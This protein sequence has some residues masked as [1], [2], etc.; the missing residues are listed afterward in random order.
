M[1]EYENVRLAML[2]MP[3]AAVLPNVQVLQEFMNSKWRDVPAWRAA[4]RQGN[5]LTLEADTCVVGITLI[6]RP[7]PWDQLAGPCATA[8]YWPQAEQVM[9]RHEQH[10]LVP[11]VDESRDQ[12]AAAMRLT[13]L[14]AAIAECSGALGI[15]WGGSRTVHEP[16]AFVQQAVQMS[17]QSLPLYLWVDFRIE[18]TN[19]HYSAFTTGM[20]TLGHQELEADAFTGQPQVLLESLYNVAHYVLDKR[21]D[22]QGGETVGL[23]E[24]RSVTVQ[25]SN[26][27]LDPDK[28]VTRLVF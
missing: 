19:S 8:W 12:I 22:F 23:S 24:Q 17:P 4:N 16:G 25:Q 2:A 28:Q 11:L 9:R 13:Q 15:F 5:V 10:F 1:P 18:E 27:M 26:S 6:P 14:V 21:Q 3:S 7:M 20:E